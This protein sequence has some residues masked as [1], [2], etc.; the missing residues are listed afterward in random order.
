M[1]PGQIVNGI[2]DLRNCV[3]SYL[4]ETQLRKT[5]SCIEESEKISRERYFTFLNNMKPRRKYVYDPLDIEKETFMMTN[6][7]IEMRN[8]R[9][10]YMYGFTLTLKKKYQKFDPKQLHRFVHKDIDKFFKDI[11][12]YHIFPEF[13]NNGNLHYHGIC[14]NTWQATLEMALRRWRRKYGF[15][16]PE[17]NLSNYDAWIRYI[18]K[19]RRRSGLYVIDKDGKSFAQR[20]LTSLK[21]VKRFGDFRRKISEYFKIKKKL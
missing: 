7:I 19:Q 15:V 13:D 8:N 16:K 12:K 11:P 18:I 21:G 17:L 20:T 3:S 2:I 5:K 1:K 4:T 10:D 6:R 9:D 14:W